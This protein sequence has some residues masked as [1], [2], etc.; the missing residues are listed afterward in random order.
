M[1]P[2]F[3]GRLTSDSLPRHALIDPRTAFE[4]PRP[5][6]GRYAAAVVFDLQHEARPAPFRRGPG[7]RANRNRA[8]A[9]FA[10]VVHQI[11]GELQKVAGIDRICG[12]G[13]DRES[14]PHAFVGIDLCEG[15]A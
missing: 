10:G 2:R 14:H 8:P 5:L 3:P 13:R 9:I 15:R 11:A 6:G 4:Y 1:P 12:S 7:S